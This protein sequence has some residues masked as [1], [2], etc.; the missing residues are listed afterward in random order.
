MTVDELIKILSKIP[1]EKRKLEIVMEG[2]DS[3]FYTISHLEP[4][5]CKEGRVIDN[6]DK[7]FT[8]NAIAIFN[9]F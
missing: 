6:D 2:E 4:V 3:W 1:P 7:P 9:V 5:L 8:P